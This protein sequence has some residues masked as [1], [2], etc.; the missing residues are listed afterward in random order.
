M[1]TLFVLLDGAED[2]DIPEFNGKRPMDVAKMPFMDSVAKN[3]GY[4][5]GRE[6]THLFLN[7]FLTGHPPELPRA[8]IEALGLDMN[9]NG[10]TAY[11]LSPAYIRNGTVE[12]AYNMEELHEALTSRVLENLHLLGDHDPEIEFFLNGR[13]ILTMNCDDI[14]DLPSPPMPA[15]YRAVSGPLGKLIETVTDKDGLTVYPWGCGRLGKQNEIHECVKDLTAISDSPTALGIC[16]SLGQKYKF[17]RNLDDRFPIALKDLENSNV[18]LHMDEVDEYSHQKDPIKKVKVLEHIDEL[19]EKYFSDA[20]RIVYFV[21]HG[22]SSI[23]GEHLPVTVP[24]WTS[25]DTSVG[26]NE[27]VPPGSMLPRIMSLRRK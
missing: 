12:W 13:A 23:T 26:E 17:I 7:E 8:V 25:F 2:H 10:R 20:E 11:R 5:D 16:A 15:S 18:L 24:F 14:P 3:K 21:D 22:T 9:M 4:T 6:Y 19:M 1:N 27:K